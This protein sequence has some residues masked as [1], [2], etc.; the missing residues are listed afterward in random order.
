MKTYVHA[1]LMFVAFTLVTALVIR[2]MV[3]AANV[4]LLKDVL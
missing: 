4:P 3:R 2:P 1:Y